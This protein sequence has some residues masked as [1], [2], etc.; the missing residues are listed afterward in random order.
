[1]VSVVARSIERGVGVDKRGGK[2]DIRHGATFLKIDSVHSL[3]TLSSQ[4]HLR[5]RFIV[6]FILA[7][8]VL[9]GW[10]SVCRAKRNRIER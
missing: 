1:M 2:R 6:Y 10:Y 9:G 4:E 5:V 3:D 7:R 8:M